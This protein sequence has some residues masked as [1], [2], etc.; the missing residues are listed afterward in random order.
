MDK[1]QS[2][3]PIVWIVALFKNIMKIILVPK[4][5]KGLSFVVL[6]TK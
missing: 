4:V 3:T 5:E 2:S 1:K 6:R